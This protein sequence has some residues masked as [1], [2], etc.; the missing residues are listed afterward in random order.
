MNDIYVL[1]ATNIPIL[2]GGQKMI[3]DI[4][5]ALLVLVPIA[6]ACMIAYHSVRKMLSDSDPNVVERRNKSI[7]NVL[8]A[9]AIGETAS[10]IV[11]FV[12]G[13]MK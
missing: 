9:A 3:Q 1:A 2:S 4:S 10:T 8:I 7:K 11:T 5:T 12:T 6:A 13:Y